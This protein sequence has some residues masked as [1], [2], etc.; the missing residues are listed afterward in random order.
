M[1]REEK[2][3]ILKMVDGKSYTDGYF[4]SYNEIAGW[5]RQNNYFIEIY[6]RRL[7]QRR[8][9]VIRQ[10]KCN[11]GA[12]VWDRDYKKIHADIIKVDRVEIGV[13]KGSDEKG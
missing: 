11:N 6:G 3:Y 7:S 4:K 10:V 5:L 2:V 8:I 1:R 13:D 12:V 9:D